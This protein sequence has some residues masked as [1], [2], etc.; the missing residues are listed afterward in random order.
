MA[1]KSRQHREKTVKQTIL[2]LWLLFCGSLGL[3]AYETSVAEFLVSNESDQRAV[4]DGPTFNSKLFT[5]LVT[6]DSQGS[7]GFR[8]HPATQTNGAVRSMTDAAQVCEMNG[9]ETLVFGQINQREAS[10]DVEIHIYSYS[11]GKVERKI[12]LR[13]APDDYQNLISDCAQKIYDYFARQLHLKQITS[14]AVEEKNS[15]VTNQGACWWGMNEPWSGS[16]VAIAGYMGS[17][18]FRLGEP[19][20]ARGD[21]SLSQEFGVSAAFE[22]AMNQP[23]V[24]P[25]ELYDVQFGPMAC[26]DLSWQRKHE[27]VVSL[28]PLAK[29]HFLDYRPLYS[30]TRLSAT[31]WYGGALDLA[32]RIW[33]NPSR[34]FGLV[35]DAGLSS[36]VT[37]PFYLEYHAGVA[38]AW[39][40]AFK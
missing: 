31:T 7:I 4:V 29:F 25:S 16:L 35:M 27:F 23:E 18:A 22:Y 5:D 11:E 14:S 8:F 3:S 36:F 19:L 39:K 26:W 6:L 38:L 12:L 21:W 10:I 13:S 17:C 40:G 20:W 9:W 32:Y 33:I 24:I 2:V 37:E 15:W 30:S 34:T 28:I 1:K